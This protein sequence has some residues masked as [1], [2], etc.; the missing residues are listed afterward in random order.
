M[1][2]VSAGKR[3]FRPGVV[4]ILYIDCRG[5]GGGQRGAA[6]G[7]RGRGTCNNHEINC[8]PHHPPPRGDSYADGL[9]ERFTKRFVGG[10]GLEEVGEEAE[11]AVLGCVRVCVNKWA[12]RGR[13]GE[14]KTYRDHPS[15]PSMLPVYT[16]P[17]LPSCLIVR[18]DGL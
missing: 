6:V 1:E 4:A 10:E 12:K 7:R 9:V 11:E 3:G 14:G 13:G 16:P 17:S 2:M 8:T 5:R 18:G 15:A